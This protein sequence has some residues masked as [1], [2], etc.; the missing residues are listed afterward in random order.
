MPAG[1]DETTFGVAESVLGADSDATEEEEEDSG[2]D[3]AAG[4]L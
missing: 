2:V 4:V 3:S 1:Q